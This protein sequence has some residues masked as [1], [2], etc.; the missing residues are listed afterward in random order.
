VEA[1]LNKFKSIFYLLA[2]IVVAILQTTLMQAMAIKGISP[3][4]VLIFLVFLSMKEGAMIGVYA[5]FF[6]GICLDV[7]SPQYLGIG[8]FAKSIVGYLTGLLDERN[9]KI[10]DRYKLV[11][12]CVASILHDTITSIGVYGA[13]ITFN[14]LLLSDILPTAIYTTM[15]G[16]IILLVLIRR[17]YYGDAKHIG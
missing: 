9:I 13:A 2:F 6:T 10:D 3:D 17:G 1:L 7:Y 14:R 12:L 5:G 15:F 4:L 11:V 16:G 8:S